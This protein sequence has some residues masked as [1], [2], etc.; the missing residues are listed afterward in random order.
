M[1]VIRIGI[2]SVSVCLAQDG[3]HLEFRSQ[4]EIT[5]KLAITIGNWQSLSI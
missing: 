4:K 5:L 2:I 1:L 3:T